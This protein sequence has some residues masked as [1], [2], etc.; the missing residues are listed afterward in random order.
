MTILAEPGPDG[1]PMNAPASKTSV[2]RQYLAA[3]ANHGDSP[4]AVLWPKGRQDLR[5]HALT[6]HLPRGDFSLLDYGC[7]LA[8][9]RAFL[10]TRFERFSYTGADM[11]AEFVHLARAKY[12]GSQFLLVDRPQGLGSDYDHILLSGVFNMLYSDNEEQHRQEVWSSLEFL[13]ARARASI[14][15]NFMTDHV[16][17]RQPGAFHLDPRELLAFVR[18]RLSRRFFLDQSYMPFEYTVVVWK[19][20]SIR[21]PGMVFG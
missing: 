9:L 15:V 5:F 11:I 14:A 1:A 10:E 16:D 7:G 2:A 3:L 6:R 19:D 18:T 12:P 13:F 4:A 20:Q 17:F 8:H 21:R